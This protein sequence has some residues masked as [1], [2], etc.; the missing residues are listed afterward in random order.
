MD[1]L[2]R[3]LLLLLS[4]C[5]AVLFLGGAWA[6][7]SQLSPQG[8][9]LLRLN[10][11]VILGGLFP[12]HEA[13]LGHERCGPIK[14]EKGIQR[15]EA[16]LYALDTINADPAL[17]PGVSLGAFVL[18]TCS[19]D[20]HALEQAMEFVKSS[21]TEDASEIRCPGNGA[22]ILPPKQPV[23]GVIGAASSSASVMVA[24]ILRL[25]QIPQVSYAST[26]TELSDKDRFGFFSRVVPADSFQAQAMVDIILQLGWTYVSTV[27]V[28]GEYGER[29]IAAFTELAEK[30]GICVAVN[31]KIARNAQ[32]EHF[33]PIVRNLARHKNAR[34]VV[35]FVDEDNCRKLLQTSRKLH[36]E[37]H[38]VWVGSDSWGAKSHPV[39]NLETAA[40]GAITV[41]PQ[42]TALPGFD[43]YFKNLR[44]SNNERN[45]WFREFWEQ[46]F[47]CSFK[48]FTSKTRCKDD[49]HLPYEQEGLV[50]YVVDAV[51]AVAHALHNMLTYK[52]SQT[53]TLVCDAAKGKP[54]GEELLQYIRNVSFVGMTNRVVKFNQK[55]G[56]AYGVYDIFQYQKRGNKYEYY[57]VGEWADRLTLNLSLTQWRGLPRRKVPSSICSRPCP[58]GSIRNYLGKN[59]CCWKCAPCREEEFIFNE[60][61]VACPQ[62]F[63][64]LEDKSSG[65]YKL[66][67]EYI[68]WSSPWAL[69]PLVFASVGIVFTLFVLA[70]FVRYSDTPIIM[71]SGRELC[72]VLL[73][74][75]LCCYCTSF[76]VVARP[77]V[78]TCTLLRLGL[79]LCLSTCYS[80]ILTK[81][82]RI[83]RIFNRGLK[84]IKRP[85]YTSP[86]SQVA[87]C[88]ALVGV[89]FI[90]S[91]AWLVMEE[92]RTREHYPTY[93]TVVLQCGVSHVSL[94][95]SLLY[96][97]VLIVLCTVYAFKT[98]K[99]PENFNEAKYIGFT[100]YSTCIVWLAFIPIYFGTNND[101]KI[102]I[103]SICMCISISASVAVCCL[104]IP[105]VYIVLFQS[106]KNVRQTGSQSSAHKSRFALS[107]TPT[108]GSSQAGCPRP[109]QPN[110]DL[111]TS[112][113]MDESSVD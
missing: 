102:Q 97:M 95:V 54:D 91:I 16:M 45:V 47:N 112:P 36:H 27:A 43:A 1:H 19:R 107:K 41:L 84:S 25:F 29:G 28:E 30:A 92:P 99:I 5:V 101:Y 42:R 63:A 44:P 69:V 14:E 21:I 33:E 111:T 83:S 64:P 31:E 90:G 72:Y 87:I 38:F 35:L 77:T 67:V 13:G 11:S 96:N 15:M 82:N 6:S 81:T 56:D 58:M 49:D 34:V 8:K 12:M 71:A 18:D 10:G 75:I 108:Q 24:N 17:L 59:R 50:P 88:L 78:F 7:Q 53:G 80:A 106:Y 100:M 32:L 61:C 74:G 109:L 2:R 22:P 20:T 9:K 89:Q 39:R 55:N 70:V 68:T 94:M 60:T 93:F 65:C 76:V 86:R 23:A 79:G 105:K 46:H 110:G 37:G 52:C 57:H 103:A 3:F 4:P 62:G 98:R 113:S 26:S 48:S 51:Y 40:E 104:F 85:S 73:V 66:P